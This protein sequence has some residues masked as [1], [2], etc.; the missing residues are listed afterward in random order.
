MRPSSGAVRAKA[1]RTPSAG[2]A[3]MEVPDNFAIGVWEIRQVRGRCHDHGVTKFFKN[4]TG[5]ET[6]REET[7]SRDQESTVHTE[8]LILASNLPLESPNGLDT[9]NKLNDG[10]EIGREV[11]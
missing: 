5:P 6:R 3:Q 2:I 4:V 8:E 11:S 1:L 9:R 7:K 10:R